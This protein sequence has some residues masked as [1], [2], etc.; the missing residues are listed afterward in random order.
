MNRYLLR[1]LVSVVLFTL[2]ASAFS[3]VKLAE[4]SEV[5]KFYDGGT[6]ITYIEVKGFP[7]SEEVRDFVSKKVLEHPDVSRVIVYKDGKTFM[8][9]AKAAI[10][11]DMVVDMVNDALNEYRLVMGD[12]PE[13]KEFDDVKP[14]TTPAQYTIKEDNSEVAPGS[15]TV[16]PVE[17]P[18][19]SSTQK[20]TDNVNTK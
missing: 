15:Y 10:E 20:P 16:V 17:R 14:K 8:Y 6:R 13:W 1:V 5:T 11:P 2:S 7:N 12:F 9:D 3:Q 19:K 18:Q 4:N